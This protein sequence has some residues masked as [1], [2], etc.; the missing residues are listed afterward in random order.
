ME[1]KVEP[2]APAVLTT[3][4]MPIAEIVEA[5]TT[6]LKAVARE[7]FEPPA[8]GAFVR[9]TSDRR[10]TFAVVSRVEHASIDPT[11]RAIPLGRTWEELRREQPQVLELLVTEFEALAVA[12]SEEGGGVNPYLPPVP[13]RVHDFVHPCSPE[14]IRALTQDLTFIRTLAASGLPA[15]DELIAAA[16]REGAGARDDRR[17]FMLRAGREVADLCRQ[18]YDQARSILRRLGMRV[19]GD[20]VERTPPDRVAIRKESDK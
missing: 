19:A 8:F 13:P 18:D 5:S 12:F 11:R 20:G 1:T 14:E 17:A 3:P 9:T 10:T 6:G 15:T 2:G 7:T 4:P 16:I